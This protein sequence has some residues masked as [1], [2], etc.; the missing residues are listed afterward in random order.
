MAVDTHVFRVANRNRP[1]KQQQKPRL[2]TEKELVKHIPEE[3]IPIAH[4]G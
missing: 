2:E 1:D 3:Q 4:T